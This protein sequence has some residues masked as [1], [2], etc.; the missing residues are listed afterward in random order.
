[1]YIYD[2]EGGLTTRSLLALSAPV[3]HKLLSPCI[4]KLKQLVREY[5]SNV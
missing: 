5:N 4:T 3:S 1:M 2:I